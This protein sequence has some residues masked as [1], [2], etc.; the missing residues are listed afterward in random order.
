MIYIHSDVLL[1]VVVR[2]FFPS[3][4]GVAMSLVVT[5]VRG[6]IEIVGYLSVVVYV[7]CGHDES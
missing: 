1:I 3:D 5:V 4:V 2:W 7:H 6:W